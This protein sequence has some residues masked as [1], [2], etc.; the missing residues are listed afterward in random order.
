MDK[1]IKLGVEAKLHDT[2]VQEIETAGYSLDISE[3]KAFELMEEE[4]VRHN[5]A[6]AKIMKSGP[7][8]REEKDELILKDHNC[9]DNEY[10]N[11][12]EYCNN[13]R[14]MYKTN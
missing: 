13:I 12:C 5:V 3:S 11:D 6:W 2:K 14:K 1:L 8:S 7:I 4:Q 10:G 9:K